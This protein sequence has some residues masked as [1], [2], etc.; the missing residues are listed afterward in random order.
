MKQKDDERLDTL[1][2]RKEQKYLSEA[3]A[4]I[5]VV[6]AGADYWRKVRTWAGN[7]ADIRPS[8]LLMLDVAAAMP[9]RLPNEKHCIRLLE[10]RALYEG[11]A[12]TESRT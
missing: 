5:A 11:K 2:A 9:R 1:D 7:S 10:I 6:K 4:H 8:D 3:E 12:K